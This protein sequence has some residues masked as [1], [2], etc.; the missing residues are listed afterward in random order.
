MATYYTLA[1][2]EDGRW[3]P[4]FGD[5]D[6]D[7]VKDEMWDTY[8]DEGYSPKDLKILRTDEAQSAINAAIAQLNAA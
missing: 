3:A 1:V 7:V 6:K 5:Y 4:Q 8:L 2:R